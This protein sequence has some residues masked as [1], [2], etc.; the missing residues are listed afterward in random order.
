MRRR[1]RERIVLFYAR[2]MCISAL[3][4]ALTRQ[5]HQ[6]NKSKAQE[7]KKM[8]KVRVIKC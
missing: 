4:N 3:P 2:L 1:R 5:A 7:V 8:S 6:M